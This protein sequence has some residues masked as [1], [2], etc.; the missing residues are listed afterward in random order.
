[1]CESEKINKLF[2]QFYRATPL[3][4]RS[5]GRINLIG[6]HTD[7]NEGFVLPAAIDK[8]IFVAATKRTDTNIQMYSVEYNEHYLADIT[9]LTKVPHHWSTYVLGV[10][11]Q[12]KQQGYNINGFDLLIDSDVPV[13]AGMSS[14][15]ALECATIFALNELF[16]LQLSKLEMVKLAQKAEQQFAGVQCGIMDMFTSMFGKREQVI[17]LDCKTLEHNY[18]SFNDAGIK[19]VLLDTNIKHSHAS[20][21][22]NT[23]KQQCE[24][25]VA[26]IQKHVPEI[27]SLR[28]VNKQHIEQYLKDAE[29]LIYKRCKFVVEENMR[30]ISACEDLEK[31]K[32]DAFGRKMYATHNGLSKEYE[33]SCKELDLLVDLVKPIQGVYGAHMMGGG[34]GG[35]TINLVKDTAVERM[36]YEVRNTY[37]DQTGKN[38]SAY[39]TTID[40]GTSIVEENMFNAV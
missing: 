33:V 12:L 11:A 5:P 28:D 30:L 13:G 7:Y 24:Y 16:N 18:V 3:I 35:C 36:I 4:V 23:R 20:S 25:G 1:M 15:A 40:E 26:L 34:F 38:V 19:I 39:I 21:E 6:E 8:S 37:R 32:I 17:K 2:Y 22:Y 14:S 10:A 27:K 31:N 29:P 9:T